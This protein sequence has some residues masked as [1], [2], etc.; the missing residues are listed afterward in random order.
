MVSLVFLGAVVVGFGGVIAHSAYHARAFRSPAA[1]AASV[2][3][4][5]TAATRL[6]EYAIYAVL[7][8]GIVLVATSDDTFSLGDP[9]VVASFLVWALLVSAAQGAVRPAVRTMMTRAQELSPE[10][11]LSTDDEVAAASRRLMAGEAA[12]Q[13]LLVVALALLVW[14]PGA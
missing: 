4:I 13:L 8:L 9:W 3:D 14:K 12:T 6:A 1:T 10:T 7:P 5:A 2:L 11:V